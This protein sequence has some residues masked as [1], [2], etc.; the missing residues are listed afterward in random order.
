MKQQSKSAATGFLEHGIPVGE[1]VREVECNCR[2]VAD[3]ESG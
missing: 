3:D 2:R 1:M